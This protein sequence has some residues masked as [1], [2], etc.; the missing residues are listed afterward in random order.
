MSSDQGRGHEVAVVGMAGRFPG[1]ADVTA[2]WELLRH[3]KTGVVALDRAA[4]AAGEHAAFAA[5]PDHVAVAAALDGLE[6]FDAGFFRIGPRDAALM[7]PQHRHLLETAWHALEHAGYDPAR[8]PGP[9]GVFTGCGATTYLPRQLLANQAL[10]AQLGLFY[11]RHAGNDKDFLATR[12]SYAL[13]LTGPSLSVQCGG[14]TGLAAVHLA[15]QSL[16]ARECDLALAGGVTIDIPA[17]RGYLAGDDGEF[18][19]QGVCRPFDS[20]ADGTVPGSGAAVVVL[21]RL[22]DAR[23]DGDTI[24]AVIAGSATGYVGSPEVA[25][26]PLAALIEEALDRAGASAADLGLVAAGTGVRAAD[27]AELAALDRVFAAA[28]QPARARLV[29]IA[30]AVGHLDAAAGTASLIAVTQALAHGEIPPTGAA[31]TGPEAERHVPAMVATARD[32]WPTGSGPRQA[33]VCAPFDGGIAAHVVVTAA[34]PAPSATPSRPWQ[35]LTWSAR[36]PEALERSTDL[37]AAALDGADDGRL[38]D[39]AYTMA[40]GRRTFDERRVA[41]VAS[42]DEAVQVLRERQSAAMVTGR[43]ADAPAIAFAFPGGGAQYPDMARGLIEREPVF[44]EAFA[45][46]LAELE[47]LGVSG[48]D[49]VVFP[50]PDGRQAAADALRDHATLALPAIFSVGFA[51][52][53]T[54]QAWGIRPAALIGHS[55]GEYVAACLAGVWSLPDALSIV[56]TRGR[57]FDALPRGAMVSVAAPADALAAHLDETLSVAAVNGPQSTVISG[58]DQAVAALEARLADAGLDHRRL[59]IGV[60]A[61]SRELEPILPTFRQAVQ[62]IPLRPPNVP[63]ISNVTGTWLT[64]AEAVDP[65]YWVRHL[66]STVRF[67][68]GVATLLDEPRAIV[69]LGPGSQLAALVRQHPAAAIAP[70]VTST[71]RHAKET[72]DDQRTLLSAVGRLWSVGAAVDWT[73]F[74]EGETRRR[75][76][77]PTYPFARGRYWVDATR[78]V[79]TS[80]GAAAALVRPNDPAQWIGHPTWVARPAA[81]ADTSAAP[82]AWLVLAGHHPLG[83]ALA[84]ALGAGGRRVIVV[85]YGEAPAAPATGEYVVRPGDLAEY[86]RV[87]AALDTAP[88]P[89][90]IVHTWALDRSAAR[91]AEAAFDAVQAVG[92]AGGLR[93]LQAL[94]QTGRDQVRL[95]FVADGFESVAEEVATRPEVATL[96]GLALVAPAEWPGMH[97]GTLDIGD[98]AAAA[99]PVVVPR[100]MAEL[101]GATPSPRVA[102]RG[103]TRFVHQVEMAPPPG[104]APSPIELR[105]GGTYLITGGLGGVGLVHARYLARQYRAR[106]VIVSRRPPAASAAAVAELE[107]L[108]AEVLVLSADVTDR[109]AMRAAVV[110]ARQRFGVVDAVFHAAGVLEP[111]LLATLDPAGAAAAMAAKTRGTLLLDDVFADAPPALVVAFSSISSLVG[112][113]GQAAYAAASAFLSAWAAA[114]APPG[115]RRLALLY[116]PWRDAGMTARNVA[117]ADPAGAGPRHP[118]LGFRQPDVA[119]AVVFERVFRPDDDWVLGEHAVRGGPAVL[120]GAAAFATIVAALAAR[121]GTPAASCAIEDLRFASPLAVARDGAVPVRVSLAPAGA[122]WRYSVESRPAGLGWREHVTAVVEARV[123]PPPSLD[124]AVLRRRCGGERGVDSTAPHRHQAQVMEFGPR[125]QSRLEV[126]YGDDEVLA[127]IEA[128]AATAGDAGLAWHPAIVDLA[129]TAGLALVPAGAASSDGPGLW[130]PSGCDRATLWRAPGSRLLVHSRLRR[131][132]SPDRVAVFDVT[133]CDDAGAVYGEFRGWRLQ[134]VAPGRLAGTTPTGR[135]DSTRDPVSALA[136]VHGIGEDEGAVAFERALATGA[137]KLV[138]SSL[139]VGALRAH[140]A[141]LGS[142]ANPAG[143]GPRRD[144]LGT[145]FVAARSDL[146]RRLAEIWARHLGVDRVGIH[147][148]FFAL[149]G[150]SLIGL[151]VFAEIRRT[152]GATVPVD[153]L[154]GAPTVAA[155][156]QTLVAAGAPVDPAA[157]DRAPGSSAVVIQA[158]EHRP[159]LFCVHDQN[160]Y[161]LLYRDLARHLGQ[162]QP[163]VALQAAGLDDPR[164]VDRT[165]VAMATR[166]VEV[167]RRV[168]PRGPYWLAGSSLGGIVA[169]EIARQ[170]TA[171]GD[172]VALLALID[173]WTPANLR[174]WWF[175]P[176]DE[177]VWARAR[178]HVRELVTAGPRRYLDTRLRNRRAWHDYQQRARSEQERQD[179]LGAQAADHLASG[180]PMAPELLTYYLEQVYG[181][182]YRAYDAAA[183]PGTVT[184]FR[185]MERA[186]ERD[187]DP[188]LG[189]SAVALGGLEVIAVP[190]PHGLMVREPHVATLAAELRA[191]IDRALDRRAAD[192]GGTVTARRGPETP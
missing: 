101:A 123:S 137:R 129:L 105:P 169:F 39:V 118:L 36:T 78:G 30:G 173:S 48:L 163:F 75:V 57:L 120:P 154:F 181:E 65:D 140:L 182:A 24:H 107:A 54:L 43:A 47:A 102:W 172:E 141:A 55:L 13:D 15:V 9:V 42:A 189:W 151:R 92:F 70:L 186:N 4:L 17:G 93:L 49:R 132:E 180:A 66:R 108:G 133:L 69:E 149:G 58:A 110:A 40:I 111:S 38:A 174:S 32:G 124:L 3:G 142:G 46:C 166:Y 97:A 20:R 82:A 71:L 8:V 16:L 135:G 53:Q 116:G 51:L 143:G 131:G 76:P 6:A 160:G 11:V 156:A 98:A 37:M 155:L 185:A 5:R 35:L 7:D 21:R 106:L 139:D 79:Q 12:V 144:D 112:I 23:R 146:E 162:D 28:G 104:S 158:G 87:L 109:A 86:V 63:C 126:H 164:Q 167:V 60:A 89:L 50:D 191:A 176:G 103:P 22:D 80:D 52:A 85:R 94:A 27:G 19:R 59:P 90:G 125:W 34:S 10:M 62:A 2:F 153:A 88:G 99:V 33:L 147:D 119:G 67:A 114:P 127:T 161:V 18:S 138:V 81:P 190:G 96:R 122:R 100:L 165:I 187:N 159:R 95:W 44:A 145:P 77:A 157:G 150:E 175:G 179:V 130:A 68:D 113:P 61:H 45:R 84:T 74:Y 134:G 178:R 168:Q 91:D 128:P 73:A 41:V 25:A 184:L 136:D 26:A 31:D 29:S 117:A 115:Q 1:A 83:Q 183:W 177:S 121:A 72:D 192:A 171:A 14:A 188:S 56:V 170:L 64:A 148:D 152:L